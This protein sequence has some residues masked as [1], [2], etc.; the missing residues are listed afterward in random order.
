MKE[1]NLDRN[2]GNTSRI[3]L[4][5]TGSEKPGSFSVASSPSNPR[6]EPPHGANP[7]RFGNDMLVVMSPR[8]E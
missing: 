5:R 8:G 6:I 1:L 2:S 7:L 3:Q 4:I